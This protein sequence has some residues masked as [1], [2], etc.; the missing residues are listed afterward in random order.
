MTIMT[1]TPMPNIKNSKILNITTLLR[2]SIAE[3]TLISA[4]GKR[5]KNNAL[6]YF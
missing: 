6:V 3:P 5:I 2:K 4:N 1:A